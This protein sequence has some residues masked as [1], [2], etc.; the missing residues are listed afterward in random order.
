MQVELINDADAEYLLAFSL[1]TSMNEAAVSLN[2]TVSYYLLPAGMYTQ[3]FVVDGV[4]KL[5]CWRVSV[6]ILEISI[7]LLHGLLLMLQTTKFFCG[8]I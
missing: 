2:V 7:Y 1:G 6:K 8:I 5:A 3:Q 4:E